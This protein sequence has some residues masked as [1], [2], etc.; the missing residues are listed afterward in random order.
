MLVKDRRHEHTI[1]LVDCIII[2]CEKPIVASKFVLEALKCA[3][4]PAPRGAIFGGKK[5]SISIK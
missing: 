1:A 2:E 5:S 4:F 3:V